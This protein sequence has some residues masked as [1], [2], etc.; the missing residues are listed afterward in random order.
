MRNVPQNA[1]GECF[2]ALPP[3]TPA[4]EPRANCTQATR[5]DPFRSQQADTALGAQP[6]RDVPAGRP[7]LDTRHAYRF[8]GLG[9]EDSA[10]RSSTLNPN[11]GIHGLLW[12]FAVDGTGDILT[13]KRT[14]FHERKEVLESWS[15]S[16]GIRLHSR[17]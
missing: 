12:G 5:G 2:R 4:H 17:N 14:S 11:R 16:V 1:E 8:M 3:S 9:R 6:G 7:Y 13:T 10:S 15:R